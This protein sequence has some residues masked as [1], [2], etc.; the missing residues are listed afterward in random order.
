MAGVSLKAVKVAVYK[1][2]ISVVLPDGTVKMY[3]IN[4]R[5][6]RMLSLIADPYLRF[7]DTRYEEK[8]E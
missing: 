7:N 8:E 2:R 4:S 5:E 3:G 1:H 6:G